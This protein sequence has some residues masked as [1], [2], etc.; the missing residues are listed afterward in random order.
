MRTG[1]PAYE[2][3]GGYSG[4]QF[5]AAASKRFDQFWLGAFIKYDNIHHAAF[6]A[7]PLVER[8]S[9]LAAGFGISWVFARSARRVDTAE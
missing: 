5:I 2:A 8:R 7:S 9:N 3:P 1:R 6:A 4:A